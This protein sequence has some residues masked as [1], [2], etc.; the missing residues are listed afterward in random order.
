MPW[1]FYDDTITDR[2]TI[3]RGHTV[4]EPEN[5]ALVE[6]AANAMEKLGIGP[7]KGERFQ[8]ILKTGEVLFAGLNE[9]DRPI[10]ATQSS[11][12]HP[13]LRLIGEA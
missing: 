12:S 10:L 7:P 1:F 6:A 9:S 4:Y 13:A 11:V 8:T 5:V 2:A 3:V